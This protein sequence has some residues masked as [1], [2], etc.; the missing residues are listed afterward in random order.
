MCCFGFRDSHC[1]ETVRDPEVV[2]GV[3]HFNDVGYECE[4][5]ES[6]SETWDGQPSCSVARDEKDR[7]GERFEFW[8]EAGCCGGHPQLVEFRPDEGT[9]CGLRCGDR[10]LLE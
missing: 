5:R 7:A 2:P 9:R 10:N 8:I 1:L 6:A 4:R 3:D